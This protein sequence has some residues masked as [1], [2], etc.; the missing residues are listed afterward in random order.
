MRKLMWIAVVFLAGTS[1]AS[2]GP[3]LPKM[4]MTPGEILSGGPGDTPN[5]KFPGVSLKLLFGDP[6][7]AG[8]YS[9]LFFVPPHTT[10]QAH[11]HPDDRMA[12]VVSGQWSVGYGARFD[13][14]LLKA[15]SPG[16]VYSE[17]AGVNHFARSGDETVIVHVCGYGPSGAYYV[18]PRNDPTLLE[19]KSIIK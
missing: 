5:P 4:R 11:S 14:T 8:F 12:T 1:A 2:T 6:A 3:S 13:E 16:S 19:K 10:I 7:K 17:P 9:L 18:D 15:L